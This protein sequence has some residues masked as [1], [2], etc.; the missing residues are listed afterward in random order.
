[1]QS[2]LAMVTDDI[3]ES[4]EVHKIL[5]VTILNLQKKMNPLSKFVLSST[6]FRDNF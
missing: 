5:K 2:Y 1:M 6:F 3:T 4:V